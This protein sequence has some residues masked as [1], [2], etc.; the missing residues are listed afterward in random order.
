MIQLQLPDSGKTTERK[1]T[2]KREAVLLYNSSEVP[3]VKRKQLNVWKRMLLRDSAD[4]GCFLQDTAIARRVR[5]LCLE[6]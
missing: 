3:L 6:K 5:W 1:H 2:M 4:S